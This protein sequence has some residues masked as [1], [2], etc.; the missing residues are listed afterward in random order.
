MDRSFKSYKPQTFLQPSSS[1]AFAIPLY[2]SLILINLLMIIGGLVYLFSDIVSAIWNVYGALLILTLLG[3]IVVALIRNEKARLDY[4]Y[5]LSTIIV[6]TLIPI[7]NTI[8]ASNL[9]NTSSR[10]VVT[11]ILVFYLLILGSIMTLSKRNN[12]GSTPFIFSSSYNKPRKSKI[13]FTILTSL[14]LLLGAYVSFLILQGQSGGFFEMFFPGYG[15]FFS[16]STLAV[17][18]LIIKM[19][20]NN[21]LVKFLVT[22]VGIGIAV[23]FSLP[24]F[25]TIAY[26]PKAGENFAAAFGD[27]WR[28][29]TTED[30][31]YFAETPFSLPAYFFGKATDDYIVKENILYYEG[32]EGVDEGIKLHFDA[33][34]PPKED[35]AS[36]EKHSVLI[37]I[38]GGGWTI[39]DKG[40]SNNAQ[41]NKYFASQGYVVFDL[42][43][44]LSNED[45]FFEYAPVPENI[46]GDFTID[47]MVRHV[48]IFTNYLVDNQDT[49]AA[50]IESVFVSGASAGGQL[51][52]AVGLGI[53]SGEYENILNPALQIKGII[54]VYAANGLAAN[55]GIEETEK[56]S[57]PSLLVGENSPPALIFQGTIDGVVDPSI[58]KAFQQIY[59]QNDAKSALLLMPFT[60]HNGDWYFSSYTNQVFI[61]YMERFMHMYK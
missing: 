1:Q 7:F 31:S 37:R 29:T 3:N 50:D 51:A 20:N 21:L 38:H 23:I 32:T 42:Q 14:L 13:V 39:G 33:Y 16:I 12:H 43:Y 18:A 48:G 4:T 24:M 61:Y 58:S 59:Q 45:K 44:G 57:D 19:N 40:A 11:I 56:L 26:I 53:A 22:L 17:M 10:S 25:T 6:M 47:D 5:L 52:N 8:A 9:S 35:T 49:F 55:V 28:N 36:D 15:L 27:E 54:P 34:M 60:G 2:N 30:I 41:V 46:V